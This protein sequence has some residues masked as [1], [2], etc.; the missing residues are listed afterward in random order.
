MSTIAN[1][2][3]TQ[4]KVFVGELAADGSIGDLGE[5]VSSFAQTAGVAAKSI[6]IEYLESLKK[7][8][9]TL[10]YRADEAP[11]PIRIRSSRL[12]SVEV[13]ANDFRALETAMA[14]AAQEHTNV[15]CHELYVTESQEFFLVI[16]THEA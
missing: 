16:M 4:F 8:V 5:N 13:L 12:P 3:H 7:I 11:Y 2:V 6:G 10:G 14:Q 9:I 15:I 1:Q